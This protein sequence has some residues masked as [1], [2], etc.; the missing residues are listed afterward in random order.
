MAI[1][2]QLVE[3][4]LSAQRPNG[5]GQLCRYGINPIRIPVF[6]QD[7]TREVIT[8][9]IVSTFTNIVFFIEYSSQMVPDAFRVS[10]VI[11]GIEI[12]GGQ[13]TQMLL[14]DGRQTYLEITDSSPSRLI[15]ENISGIVQYFELNLHL[16]AIDTEDD[17]RTV[18]NIINNW[19]SISGTDE[20]V[21]ELLE[22]IDKIMAINSGLPPAGPRKSIVGGGF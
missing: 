7:S 22:N 20:R 2:G 3:Y 6:M 11:K 15:A 8:T 4:L 13:L 17:M 1:M 14:E 12:F 19:G 9:P 21:A 10:H 18:R 16:L 5:G